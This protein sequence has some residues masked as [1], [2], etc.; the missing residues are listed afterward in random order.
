MTSRVFDDRT[1]KLG[2]G[3]LWHPERQQ[4]FSFDIVGHQLLSRTDGDTQEWDFDE[5]VSA[6]GWVNFDTLLVGS[7]QSLPGNCF[8]PSFHGRHF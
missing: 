6:A 3:P 5:H 2:E 8:L 4:F 1:C 7:G